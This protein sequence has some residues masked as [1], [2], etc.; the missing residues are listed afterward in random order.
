MEL[1]LAVGDVPKQEV[2]HAF[3]SPGPDHEVGGRS[4]PEIRN[5]RDEGFVDP[6][7]FKPPVNCHPCDLLGDA[8]QLIPTAIIN[9]DVQV[10]ALAPLGD[11]LDML[12]G[13]LHGLEQTGSATD[14]ADANPFADK[15]LKFAIEVDPQQ[16]EEGVDLSFG[17]TP[18]L[19]REGVKGEISY[20]EVRGDAD[21]FLDPQDTF[22][23]AD[24]PGQAATCRPATI[25]IQD[26]C[27]VECG[28]F[29]HYD[30]DGSE[31]LRWC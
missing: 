18:V 14:E 15:F 24:A 23:V 1:E 17:T 16:L 5:R 6:V 31:K 21:A 3:V 12:H 4:V 26:D 19:G 8:R 28:D 2:G 20:A 13:L 9:R 30:R 29:L 25:A 22:P 11:G 10:Q 27:D 7:D